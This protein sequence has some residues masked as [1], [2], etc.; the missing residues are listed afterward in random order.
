[1]LAQDTAL[2]AM[3]PEV[4]PGVNS[5][6]VSARRP[7]GGTDVLLFEKDI[8]LDWP[9]PYVFANPIVFRRGTALSV[10]AYYTNAG[11]ASAPGGVR[12]TV[13]G[14]SPVATRARQK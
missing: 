4:G 7:D 11:T 8:P 3:R 9:T 14:S 13:S 5:V 6:E 10:T 2:L 1:M 12:L